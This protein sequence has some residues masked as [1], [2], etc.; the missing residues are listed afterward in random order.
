MD[1]VNIGLQ[2]KI[3][4]SKSFSHK[5]VFKIFFNQNKIRNRTEYPKADTFKY[6]VNTLMKFY[7]Y[8]RN[9]TYEDVLPIISVYVDN[10]T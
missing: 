7:G 2:Q 10:R 6:K 4:I 5:A 1:E 9:T 3:I 8:L